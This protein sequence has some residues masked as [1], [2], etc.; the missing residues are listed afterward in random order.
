MGIYAWTPV[1]CFFLVGQGN[2]FIC[3]QN[4]RSLVFQVSSKTAN[5]REKPCLPNYN[6]PSCVSDNTG[7][8]TFSETNN[9]RAL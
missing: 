6:A 1:L 2:T 7:L 8:Y 5:N 9:S 4:G 3:L